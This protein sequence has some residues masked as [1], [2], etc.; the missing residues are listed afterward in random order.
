MDYA[1]QSR[2]SGLARA[3][4]MPKRV[5][6]VAI[7]KGIN[8]ELNRFV[9]RVHQLAERL[10]ALR[11]TVGDKITKIIGPPAPEPMN[12]TC[13]GDPA[14]SCTMAALENSI[15][16]AEANFNSLCEELERML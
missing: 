6:D 1:H 16:L 4:A 13:K 12:G 11:N 2:T 7:D 9:D 3:E 5:P 10:S 14:S 8:A 15:G